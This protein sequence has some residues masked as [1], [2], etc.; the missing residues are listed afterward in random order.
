MSGGRLTVAFPVVSSPPADCVVLVPS[1]KCPRKPGTDRAQL[2]CETAVRSDTHAV[3]RAL[4]AVH[5]WRGTHGVPAVCQDR[6]SGVG[7]VDVRP[8]E[9]KLTKV[10][11]YPPL[12]TPP[13]ESGCCGSQ[14]GTS[15]SN[16]LLCIYKKSWLP[17]CCL[18]SGES[19]PRARSPARSSP[20]TRGREEALEPRVR[21]AP[22]GGRI[23]PARR[24]P[25]AP[26]APE[27]LQD[28]P[29]GLAPPGRG[30]AR[31][32]LLSGHYIYYH[33]G[34][35]G[36]DDPGWGRVYRTLQTLCSWPEGRPA[37]VPELAAVQA[38]LEDTGD[39]PPGLRGARGWIGCVEASLCLDHLGG[40]P[41]APM[42]RAP[43]SRAS[44]GT[45]EALFPL[46]RGWGGL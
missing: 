2:H 17:R 42:S 25:L 37:G 7:D 36:V 15:S 43:W 35:D 5:I 10:P 8:G 27:P 1:C 34:C 9:K 24:P 12:A 41:R 20:K 45:G 13:G 22:P 38:A 3:R 26:T 6:V 30:R 18:G 14:L 46:G 28:V 16:N 40:P 19:D 31:L 4:W 21:P 44:G 23:C 39:K 33:Y 11:V 32:A 29:L